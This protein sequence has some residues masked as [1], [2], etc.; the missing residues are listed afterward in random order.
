ML[1][2]LLSN[3]IT[4]LI[5]YPAIELT[6]YLTNWALLLSLAVALMVLKGSLD[7]NIKKKKG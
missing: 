3:L 7:P 1:F 5:L 4:A 2:G 6:V